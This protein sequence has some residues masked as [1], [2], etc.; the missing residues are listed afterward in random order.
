MKEVLQHAHTDCTDAFS[1][2]DNYVF[3]VSFFVAMFVQGV[4]KTTFEIIFFFYY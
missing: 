2:S 1:V 4:V 3:S